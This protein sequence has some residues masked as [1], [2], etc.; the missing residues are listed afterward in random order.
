MIL[1]LGCGDDMIGEVRIDR[2]PGA[3]ALNIMGDAHSL[4]FRDKVFDETLC[5]SVFEHVEN[6][7]KSLLEMTR[8]SKSK[9]R[10]IIP[11][12][13]YFKRIL[14]A[15]IKPG[16]K[17]NPGTLHLQAWDLLALKRLLKQVEAVEILNVEWINC[18]GL[19]SWPSLFFGLK[20]R[21]TMGVDEVRT[22]EE[23]TN[24]EKCYF[25]KNLCMGWCEFIDGPCRLDKM[26]C[27]G[28][29]FKP[30]S[31]FKENPE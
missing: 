21:V 6:P 27:E 26:S 18:P 2:R 1:N 4:P 25:C 8:V 10:V 12:V 14:R 9:L 20:M 22:L 16:Y 28:K 31:A 30:D 23:K 15:L 11:N 5:Y 24:G 3:H 19:I 29:G 13:Y 7:Y 17:V